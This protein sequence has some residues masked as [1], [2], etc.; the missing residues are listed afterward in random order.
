[1][2]LGLHTPGAKGFDAALERAIGFGCEAMQMLPYR[3]HQDPEDED[4]SGFKA[5]RAASPVKRLLIHS[6]FV[7]SLA[8]SDERRR[9][10]SIELLA[11]ELD[12]A[13]RWGADGYVLHAGAYSP[14]LSREDGVKLAARSI[15]AAAQK[16]SANVP[17]YVE[18]VPGGGRR[19]GGTLEELAALLEAL[20]LSRVRARACFDTAHAWA[21]GYELATAEGMLKL[22][23]KAHR[24]LGDRLSA[25][26][27][28]DTR[29]KLGS[30]LESHANWGEG[31]LGR[32]GLTVLLERPEF[33]HA[34]GIVEPPRPWLH[35][36]E[37]L[38]FVRACLAPAR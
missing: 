12:L 14:D 35:D 7:P 13:A 24:L 27:V 34:V 9:N 33:E 8:S 3:R 5:K 21:A 31:F 6:R 37:S 17:I 23:A 10:R 25:F 4:Y 20:E 1:M 38:A 2:L 28:N 16:A 15:A 22:L 32:E 11:L 30:N 19:M 26:H 29:A 18:N 36:G